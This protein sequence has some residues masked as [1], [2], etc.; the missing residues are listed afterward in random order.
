LAVLVAMTA[1]THSSLYLLHISAIDFNQA[2]VQSSGLSSFQVKGEIF[3]KSFFLFTHLVNA[4][5]LLYFVNLL[6]ILSSSD[7]KAHTHS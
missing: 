6:K 3:T 7:C 2:I 1:S 5:S 4:N